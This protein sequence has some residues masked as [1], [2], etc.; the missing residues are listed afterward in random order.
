MEKEEAT[1]TESIP[2]LTPYTMKTFHLSHRVVLAPLSRLRSYNFTAQPHAILY[3]KQ[4]TTKG[5]LLIGEAS[6]ISDTAQGL[7]NTPGIWKKE[8]VEAWRPIVD[9]VHENGGII[10]CQLWHSGRVS[11]TC[12]QPNG[13]SPISSTNKPIQNQQFIG[14][15]GD[16]DSQYSPP[17]RLTIDEI[18]NVI[19]DFRTAARN[20]MEAGFDGV[21]IH[22]ANG[23]LVDQFMKDQVNDR[24]DQYGGSLE[25]RCRFPLEVVQAISEEIGCER[26]GMRLSPFAN[27]N[28]SADSDPHSLGVFM[29]EALSQLRIAYCHVIQPRMVTQFERVETRDS[30]ASMRKA[31]KGTFIVAGGY[32]DREEANRV[33]ENGEADLVAFGRAFL[34]NPDLPRRFRLNAPLNMYD[35]STFYTDDPVVGY[36]DYPF[37][38]DPV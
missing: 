16:A 26:V 32:Y 28:D 38:E 6:G 15:S 33:I 3:Y 23:Y 1:S 31:F 13:R 27:Y 20:A 2:L 4:R 21:E 9:G 8:H 30:L 19:N 14:G 18:S 17:H 10:F 35:R 29:A 5:G 37:L 22:G 25:N 11:N 36:T 7:P 24:T 34:A 12:F